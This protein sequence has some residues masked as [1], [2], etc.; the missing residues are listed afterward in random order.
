MNICRIGNVIVIENEVFRYE[1]IGDVSHLV[2]HKKV[3]SLRVL[4]T[5]VKQ[6]VKTI[7]EA[8]KENK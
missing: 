4:K 8:E 1:R 3:E 5:L 2:V 6:L 7:T